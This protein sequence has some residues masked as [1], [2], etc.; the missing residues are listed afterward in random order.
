MELV[1]NYVIGGI[2][3][4]LG[5]LLSQLLAKHFS[6]TRLTG[7]FIIGCTIYPLEIDNYFKFIAHLRLS[8]SFC[9]KW[10]VEQVEEGYRLNGLGRTVGAILFFN[11][12]WIA[13]HFLFIELL[14]AKDICHNLP[15]CVSEY[16][17]LIG[18][19]CES[20]IYAIPLVLIGNYIVQTKIPL[21]YRFIGSAL[22]S[23]LFALYYGLM[24]II[25]PN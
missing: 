23:L 21:K 17:H 24:A 9:L 18:S 11:P 25:L 3:F 12:L 4:T 16:F 5:D 20:F 1:L 13:R 7:L 8:S 14:E 22:L 6:L 10:L 15:S 2:V 19:A